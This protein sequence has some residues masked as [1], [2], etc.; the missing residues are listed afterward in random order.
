MTHPR[1][2]IIG[3]GSPIRGDDAIGP[4]AAEALA[5]GP[6]PP[7]VR[8]ISR[9]IL[10]AELV[11]DIAMADRVIFLDA[12]LEGDPGEVRVQALAPDASSLSALAHSQDPRELLA[13]CQTLYRWVPAAYLV[14]AV[15][16]S[17]DYASYTLSTTA[18]AALGSLLIQ[19]HALITPRP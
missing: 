11:A 14:T 7:G 15:G 8:V 12:S 6:L 9:H 17:F 5:A 16:Q 18:S 3:Y 19:V 10:T 2:L 4:L 13:W 1:T